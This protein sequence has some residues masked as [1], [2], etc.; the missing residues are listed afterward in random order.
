MS[1]ELTDQ[2]KAGIIE[3]HMKSLEFSEY[4]LNLSVLEV[5]AMAVPNQENL[6]N[7][8]LQLSDLAAKKAVLQQELSSLNLN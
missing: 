1:I 6:D 5:Q 3:Q 8:T 4:N 2:E 7:L